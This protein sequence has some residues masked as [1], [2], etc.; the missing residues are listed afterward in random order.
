[1][2]YDGGRGSLAVGKNGATVSLNF[3]SLFIGVIVLHPLAPC[4][5]C[6][7]CFNAV[8]KAFWRCTFLPT[9]L[10]PK[11]KGA[12]SIKKFVQ[13]WN[14]IDF[15]TGKQYEIIKYSFVNICQFYKSN[16]PVSIT[17]LL[18]LLILF[19]HC[20]QGILMLHL[21]PNLFVP[22]SKQACSRKKDF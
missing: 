11:S 1:M 6:L 3:L 15:P 12:C 9:Y 21:P 10:S 22:K 14:K 18:T 2:K 7:F 13:M 5:P 20:P 19:Q 8:H 16:C 17:T 4:W